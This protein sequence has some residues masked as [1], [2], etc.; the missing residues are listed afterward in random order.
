MCVYMS[1]VI[2][3]YAKLKST[4]SPSMCLGIHDISRRKILH[5]Y[6]NIIREYVC[7]YCLILCIATN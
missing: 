2:M 3:L 1:F 4:F 7:C 5:L 6:S